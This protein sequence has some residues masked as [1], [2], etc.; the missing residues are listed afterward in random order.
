M[1]YQEALGNGSD[2]NNNQLDEVDSSSWLTDNKTYNKGKTVLLVEDNRQLRNYIQF[3]LQE[4]F[5]VIATENG[6]VALNWLTDESTP[7]PHTIISDIMMPVMDGFELLTQLKNTDKFR[8]IPV[9][10]LTARSNMD[11]KLKA[12]TI[13]V[14]DYILKPFQEEE[15]I[16]RINNLMKNRPTSELSLD[17]VMKKDKDVSNK[18][19]P[20]PSISASDI[21]WLEQIEKRFRE[22][23]S[24]SKIKIEILA[25]ELNMSRSQFQRRIKKI[26]GLTPIHY[27][28]EIRLQAA[29]QLLEN[30]E[31]RTVNEVT[32][33]VGFDTPQY[34]SKL[35]YS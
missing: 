25:E 11:D 29:R 33:A 26:T 3:I 15:L 35:Y 8:H 13:G 19:I 1:P 28:R 20:K 2:T 6:Q 23:I 21:K 7:E 27:F 5:N 16:V 32:Y 22:D 24:N 31:V 34:L 10:M 14:D 17:K 30:G 9:L 4:Q 18:A 12:L